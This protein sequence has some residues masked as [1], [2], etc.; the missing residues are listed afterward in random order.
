MAR[1]DRHD[2][3]AETDEVREV[4]G[5]PPTGH[6]AAVAVVAL[7]QRTVKRLSPLTIVDLFDSHM[8]RG[9]VDVLWTGSRSRP[10][11]HAGWRQDPG[12]RLGGRVAGRQRRGAPKPARSTRQAAELYNTPSFLPASSCRTW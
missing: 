11:L 10:L 9:Q 4:Q 5:S 3:K 8:A 12:A 7:M 6:D 1:P 2:P